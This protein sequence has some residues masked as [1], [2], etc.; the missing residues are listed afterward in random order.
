[1]GST[2]VKLGEIWLRLHY[3]DVVISV[4]WCVHIL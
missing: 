4:L 1:M 3:V 2:K